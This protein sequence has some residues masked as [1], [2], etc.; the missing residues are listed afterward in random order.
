MGFM[1]RNIKEGLLGGLVGLVLIAS[2]H[3][4]TVSNASA[5]GTGSVTSI[6]PANGTL[7]FS[8]DPITESGTIGL[9][10]GSANVWTAPLVTTG[11]ATP[12]LANGTA[13][14]YVSTTNGALLQGQGSV[15]D[16]QVLNKNG[17][18]ALQVAT[19]ALSV[20]VGGN[21][22]STNTNGYELVSG[23]ASA[24]VPT[25]VPNKASTTSGLGAAANGSVDGIAGGTDV[26]RITSGHFFGVGF[27]TSGASQTGNLCYNS[28]STPANEILLD[29]VSCLVS[30]RKFKNIKGGISGSQALG[31]VR[32][33]RP[34]WYTWNQKTHPTSDTHVQ[35]GLVA[36]E[37]ERVDPRLSA[38]DAKGRLEGVR[39]EQMT[40]L[41]VAA[42]QEQQRQIDELGWAFCLVIAGMAGMT[43]WGLKR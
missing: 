14:L 7:T 1:L 19:G 43:A 29:T 36:E 30:L 6:A 12:T 23:A 18:I 33:L 34:I 42:A 5:T 22:L 38:Y 32:A 15:N 41:M 37:V 13:A 27:G 25:A 35:P 11:T 4:Q 9:N 8:P 31:E 28:G 10:L 20:S 17:G 26:W 3:G 40:A 39:Y 21:V 24:T 2:A 16:L